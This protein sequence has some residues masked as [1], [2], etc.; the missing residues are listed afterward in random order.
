MVR[1]TLIAITDSRT[2]KEDISGNAVEKEIKNAGYEV[3]DRYVVKNNI[4]Q[5]RKTVLQAKG[6]III[7]M[8]GT[9][10]SA[11]DITPEAL[12]PILEKELFGFGELFRKLSYEDIGTSTIMSRSFAGTLK[13][14]ALF[15]LPGSTKACV[16]ATREIILT[17]C[18]HMFR[19]LRK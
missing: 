2:E 4:E 14:K 10:V 1:F 15:C 8:G 19:E 9:G 11:R 7:T 16:L 17:E 18:E 3:S 12:K 6:D 13:G 5:I